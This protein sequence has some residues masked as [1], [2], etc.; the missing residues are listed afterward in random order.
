M[1]ERLRDEIGNVMVSTP[2]VKPKWSSI[3]IALYTLYSVCL[4]D[5]EFS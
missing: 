5:Y 1:C 2:L 4:Y 3:V